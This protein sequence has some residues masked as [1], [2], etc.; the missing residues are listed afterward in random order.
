MLTSRNTFQIVRK[1]DH[2]GI[3]SLFLPQNVLREFVG[4]DVSRSGSVSGFQACDEKARASER[5]DAPSQGFRID[6][7]I[8]AVLKQ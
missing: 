3:V 4:S 1:V 2:D 8:Y 7:T 5:Q 6:L